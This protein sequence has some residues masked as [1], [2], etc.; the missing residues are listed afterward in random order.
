VAT[1]SVIPPP[2]RA[3][4]PFLNLIRSLLSLSA[5]ELNK[6]AEAVTTKD[7]FRVSSSA[8]AGLRGSLGKPAPDLLEL[9]SVCGFLYDSALS[10]EVTDADLV[11]ELLE[12]GESLEVEIPDDKVEALRSL[13]KPNP[14]YNRDRRRRSASE[15]AMPLLEQV[16]L[17]CDLRAVVAGPG[18]IEGYVPVVIA[19]LEFDEPIAGQ[20]AIVVQISQVALARLE[21][22]LAAMRDVLSG[23]EQ[24][25]GRRLL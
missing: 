4:K 11:R 5:D 10:E 23:V 19:R 9:L 17:H 25:L 24:E 18:R 14:E 12:L 20:G 16:S 15:Q 21:T 7:G 3:S 13:F 2:L 1:D 22:E 8:L 6:I